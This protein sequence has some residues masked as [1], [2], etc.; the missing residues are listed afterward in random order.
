MQPAFLL[1]IGLIGI[2]PAFLFVDGLIIHGLLAALAAVAITIIALSIR[3]GE[4]E[5]FSKIFRPIAILA[6]IVPA[7]MLIQILPIPFSY[8]VHPIWLSAQSALDRPVIGSISIDN[9]ATILAFARYCSIAGV[10]FISAAVTIDRMR[11]ELALFFLAGVTTFA[12]VILIAAGLGT[13][14]FFNESLDANTIGSITNLAALGAIVNATNAI[15]VFERHEL[16]R[17]PSDSSTVKFIGGLAIC[18]AAFAVCLGAIVFVTAPPIIFATASGLATFVIFVILRRLDLRTWENTLIVLAAVAVMIMIARVNSNADELT[19]RY[20]NLPGGLFAVTQSL[21]SHTGW[22]GNGAGTFASILP[23]YRD[24]E[25]AM[26]GSY[27]P[28]TAAAIVI[29]LG[30]PALWAILG[31]IIIL[32]TLF[33]NGA[34]RRGRDSFYPICGASCI[35][36]LTLEAFCDAGFFDTTVAI[37]AA[38]IL[39]L[40]IAQCESRTSQLRFGIG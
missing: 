37:S 4:A 3:P 7:W 29:E 26:S 22:A 25:T 15:R 20:A 40:A 38:T 18:T 31:L 9:G 6:L 5:Y 21:L 28:T 19:L 36:V 11:A 34:L 32:L 1:L 2:S 10:V 35:V 30:W 24:V 33:L 17:T 23:I 16:R 13:T 39:G 27:A 8:V 12:A 14:N